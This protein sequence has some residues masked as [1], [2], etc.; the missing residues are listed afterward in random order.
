MKIWAYGCSW[1]YYNKS[2]KIVTFWPELVAN[3]SYVVPSLN[4]AKSLIPVS[5]PT[6]ELVF[7]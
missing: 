1:T 6:F 2:E 5:I 7:S 4:M 3:K